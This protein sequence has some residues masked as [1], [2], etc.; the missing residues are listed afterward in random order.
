[1]R[2]CRTT[3][4]RK[5][6]TYADSFI[7]IYMLNEI[8]III[9]RTTAHMYHMCPCQRSPCFTIAYISFQYMFHH[10]WITWTPILGSACHT[11]FSQCQIRVPTIPPNKRRIWCW[12]WCCI[13]W[14]TLSWWLLDS[15]LDGVREGYRQLPPR[16]QRRTVGRKWWEPH[17]ECWLDER[18][19]KTNVCLRERQERKK[20]GK[21][22]WEGTGKPIEMKEKRVK[23]LFCWCDIL[24]YFDLLIH[25]FQT[26]Q[27]GIIPFRKANTQKKRHFL[28]RLIK[29]KAWLFFS[30]NIYIHKTG[31]PIGW[32]GGSCKV[33]A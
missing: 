12:S 21:G 2:V 27:S 22:A 11:E 26:P 13:W 3:F 10:C 4:T 6:Y 7:S 32:W 23:S 19:H 9:L 25:I 30:W 14:Y 15:R 29:R 5:L 17:G 18:V 24:T 1:M 8:F 33:E 20:S 28:G 16:K 31:N